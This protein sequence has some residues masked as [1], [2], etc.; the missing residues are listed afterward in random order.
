MIIGK[1]SWGLFL[2]EWTDG[3]SEGSFT[4]EE[5]LF[6]FEKNNIKIP[7]SLLKDFYNTLYRK[8]KL[9]LYGNKISN[10]A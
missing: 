1:K 10:G 4:R 9:K 2:Q 7:E 8:R 6:E 3:I 5:I